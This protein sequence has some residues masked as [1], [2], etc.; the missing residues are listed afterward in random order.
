MGFKFLKVAL[1]DLD[2]RFAHCLYYLSF[3]KLSLRI[4]FS[5]H[6]SLV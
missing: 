1:F 4:L 2:D 5:E 3:M 6:L